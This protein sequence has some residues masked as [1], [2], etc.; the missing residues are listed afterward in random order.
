M[1]KQIDKNSDDY[2]AGYEQCKKDFAQNPLSIFEL[3]P[4]MQTNAKAM[5]EKAKQDNQVPKEYQELLAKSLRGE[6]SY[7][8]LLEFIKKNN[9]KDS[10]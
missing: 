10:K 3:L 8:E 7:A 6:A 4:D 1:S 5:I 9:E 2:K